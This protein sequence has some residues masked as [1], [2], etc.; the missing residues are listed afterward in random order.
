MQECE[1]QHGQSHETDTPRKGGREFRINQAVSIRID[2][3]A[4]FSSGLVK[5]QVPLLAR[6]ETG[7]SGK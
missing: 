7:Q 5:E 6:S 4:G 2:L 3:A 1:R